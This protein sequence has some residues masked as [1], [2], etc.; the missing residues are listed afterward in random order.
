MFSRIKQ[1]LLIA[2]GLAI[3]Y[4]ILSHHFIFSNLNSVDLLEKD[5]LKL[6][7]TF[8]N[9]ADKSPEEIMGIEELRDA[10]IGDIL[11][12]RGVVSQARLDLAIQRVDS[13]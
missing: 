11:L 5:E 1:Y 4:F 6:N 8:Y 7:Y 3:F 13:K 2:I 9:I 12:E 10:G